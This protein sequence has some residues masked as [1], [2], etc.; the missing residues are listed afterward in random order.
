MHSN[1]IVCSWCIDVD[2][3]EGAVGSS[4]GKGRIVKWVL[5]KSE[6]TPVVYQNRSM[7][8]CNQVLRTCTI[9]FPPKQSEP[10]TNQKVLLPASLL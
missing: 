5:E 8:F 7:P 4:S 10:L 3:C 6:N 9:P 1:A 2:T